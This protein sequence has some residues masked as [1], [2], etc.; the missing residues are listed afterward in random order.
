VDS[1]QF[2]ALV[3]RLSTHLTRRRS[4][5]VLGVIGVASA[6]LTSE[7][8][9]KKKK[10]KGKKGNKKPTTTPTPSTNSTLPTTTLSP[11]CAACTA[12]ETCVNNTCQPRAQGAACSGN[13]VNAVCLPSVN[14]ARN[15]CVD[16]TG[17]CEH[18]ACNGDADCQSGKA[19]VD[20]RNDASCEFWFYCSPIIPA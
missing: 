8:E 6:S 7:A 4:L 1:D 10:K 2:D 3:N 16:L 17:I 19:C 5:G 20:T 12:C 11:Q 13:G 14:G 18:T 9:A 15:V